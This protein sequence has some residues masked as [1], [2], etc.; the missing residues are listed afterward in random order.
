MRFYKV[1]DDWISH[2]DGEYRRVILATLHELKLSRLQRFAPPKI[3]GLPIGNEPRIASR[4][5]KRQ[6]LQLEPSA[7]S[8]FY[9][10]RMSSDEARLYKAFRKNESLSKAEWQ[11]IIGDEAFEKWVENK[12]LWETENGFYCAFTVVSIDGLVFCVDPL[13]DHGIARNQEFV[14]TEIPQDNGTYEPFYH[15]YIGLDSLRM[16]EWMERERLPENGRYL[17]CGTGS[18]GLLLF[19]GR[20]FSEAVGLDINPRAAK[21]AKFNAKLNSM[22]NVTTFCGDAIDRSMDLGTFDLVSWNLPFIF[23]P[24][25]HSDEFIDGFGGELGI[26][27]CLK[28]VE[29]LPPLLKRDGQ[30]CIAALAPILESGENV[31]E[32]RLYKLLPELGLDCTIKVAQMSVAHTKELWDFHQQ[33]NVRNFESVY[34][35]LTLGTGKMTRVGSSGGRRMIDKV[36]ETAYRRKYQTK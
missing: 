28:F 11:K 2:L 5:L 13:N 27:L 26:G 35:F 31:L 14:Y 18:G 3:G 19:F 15:T 33:H 16:I 10:T 23:M 1:Q 17:D 6:S 21:L 9:S 25:E 4:F 7:F 20:K 12:C 36:R 32:S 24:D 34:L 30:A 8:N 29:S 22:N